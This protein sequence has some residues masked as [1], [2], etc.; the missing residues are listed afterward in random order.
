MTYKLIKKISNYFYQLL[1]LLKLLK[2]HS[3]IKLFFRGDAQRLF[4]S[5]SIDI[6]NNV[7]IGRNSWLSILDG[8]KFKIGDNT[9]IN[10]DFVVAVSSSVEIGKNVLIADRVFISDTEHGY[11][12]LEVPIL[13]Q[14]M[15]P[16][17]SV[18]IEDDCWI[19]INACILKNVTI[20]KHSVVG[21]GS[22]VTRSIPPYSVACGNP[23]KIIKKYDFQKKEW[24]RFDN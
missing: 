15:L 17:L 19:G 8:A 7:Y 13:Q 1:F 10:I 4:H 9:H 2:S 21:A 5:K 18:K 22:V 3:F 14:P 11:L 20:G 24:I 16:G 12:N 6:G 23:A